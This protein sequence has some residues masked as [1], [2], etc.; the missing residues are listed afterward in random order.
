MTNWRTNKQTA[1]QRGYGYQWQKAR[2]GYLKKHP[3]CVY[4]ERQGR[5]T[6]AEVVDHIRPHRGDMGLFWDKD[7]WQALC[8]HCHDSIKKQEESGKQRPAIGIDGWPI[9]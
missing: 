5:V 7:N 6:P 3:L 9:F 4:C 8:K 1:A 2:A